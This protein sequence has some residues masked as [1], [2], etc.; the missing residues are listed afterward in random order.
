V[1]G[2][3]DEDPLSDYRHS[4]SRIDDPE[5]AAR[6]D[7]E[8]ERRAAIADEQRALSRT[9]W[10]AYYLVLAAFCWWGWHQ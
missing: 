1:S 4:W 5:V 2:W 6:E 8:R 3:D 10:L 9:L 7:G